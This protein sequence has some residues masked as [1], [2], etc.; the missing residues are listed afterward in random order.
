[1][2]GKRNAKFYKATLL[3]MRDDSLSEIVFE[4]RNH[5]TAL[6]KANKNIKKNIRV[7]SV[8]EEAS[9]VTV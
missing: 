3:D 8:K 2:S 4:A 1:M 5:V 7:V 9:T 6:R